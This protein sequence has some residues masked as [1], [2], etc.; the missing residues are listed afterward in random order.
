MFSWCL[1]EFCAMMKATL[2]VPGWIRIKPHSLW[3]GLLDSAWNALNLNKTVRNELEIWWRTRRSKFNSAAET[4]F[5]S[6]GLTYVKLMTG[7]PTWLKC[8]FSV[9]R[10]GF[11]VGNVPSP[12]SSLSQVP[13]SQL[14]GLR[15]GF[16]CTAT[17][18]KH[19]QVKSPLSIKPW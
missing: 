18:N 5:S 13:S 9:Y 6:A 11:M 3:R 2:F 15:M 8:S 7:C 19:T 16:S 1:P 12:G 10:K 14:R 17:E 4:K